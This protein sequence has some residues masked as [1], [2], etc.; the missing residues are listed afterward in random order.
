MTFHEL[1]Q[2]YAADVY[3]FAYWLAGNEADAKDLT[4]ETF[5]RAWTAPEA[6]RQETV[7]AY[8]F[9][10]ARNLH[11][12]QW[13]RQSRLESL[14]ETMPDQA[15]PPDV[16]AGDQDECACIW[17]AVQALPELDRTV[18]ML[19]VDQDLAYEE[20]AAITGLSAGAAKVR[21]FRARAKLAGILEPP[22]NQ[23]NPEN[24]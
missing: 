4:S 3:R 1:Y 7:R 8:L 17:A 18:L 22:N 6:P 21:L 11:R 5:V 24:P 14:D 12:R 10:I 23:P 15:A 19:R 9:T 13:R 20:I 16:A 2:K